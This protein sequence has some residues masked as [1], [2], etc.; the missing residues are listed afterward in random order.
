MTIDASLS[1]AR[2]FGI[3]FP[4]GRLLRTVRR[5]SLGIAAGLL[6]LQIV[7]CASSKASDPGLGTRTLN[8]VVVQREHDVSGS[9]TA[10]YRGTGGY[11][12]VFETHEGQAIARYRLEVTRQQFQRFQQGDRVTITL[13]NNILMNIRPND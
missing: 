1:R 2:E 9:G 12:L 7:A 13:N 5:A 10:G 3:E 4:E 8:C 11:Y 6:G